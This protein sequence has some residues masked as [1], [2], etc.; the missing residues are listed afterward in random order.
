MSTERLRF[1]IGCERFYSVSEAKA[2]I[3]AHKDD[4]YRAH[5]GRYKQ[6]PVYCGNVRVGDYKYYPEMR[7][8]IKVI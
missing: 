4:K 8:V 2:Y 7:R 1:R 6:V 3:L 5:D